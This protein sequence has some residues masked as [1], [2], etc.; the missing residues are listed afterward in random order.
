MVPSLIAGNHF[1]RPRFDVAI[2]RAMLQVG[3]GFD[4]HQPCPTAEGP[5]SITLLTFEGLREIA[6]ASCRPEAVDIVI[7]A[8]R[9]VEGDRH[10]GDQPHLGMLPRPVATALVV[11]PRAQA[12]TPA[13]PAPAPTSDRVGIE[14]HVFEGYDVVKLTLAGQ[15][16]WIALEVGR[17]LEYASD[18]RGLVELLAREWREEFIDGEHLVV[19]KSEVLKEIKDAVNALGGTQRVGARVN[20]L[21]LMTRAGL[22]LVLAKTEK[23]VGARFRRWLAGE[24]RE[25]AEQGRAV[26]TGMNGEALPPAASTLPAGLRHLVPEGKLEGHRTQVARVLDEA[27]RDPTVCRWTNNRIANAFGFDG[28]AVERHR[29]A[30]EAEGAIP[31]HGILE[32]SDGRLRSRH[33]RAPGADPMGG[34][35]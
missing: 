34:A 17:A 3:M 5:A 6:A 16:C 14:R 7:D 9:V 22:W 30:L 4:V 12:P 29:R 24:V 32:S 21:T 10:A 11:T 15:D 26:E 8:T 19:A 27:L 23:P 13:A 35:H 28:K 25:A 33:S 31:A 20:A 2:R 18:G 1:V